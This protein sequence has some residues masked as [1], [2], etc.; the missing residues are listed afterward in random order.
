MIC[1]I[2]REIFAAFCPRI[3][4]AARLQSEEYIMSRIGPKY[5]L[6]RIRI[7]KGTQIYKYSAFRSDT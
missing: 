5:I 1:E 4:E 3:I 2:D 6:T 7:K